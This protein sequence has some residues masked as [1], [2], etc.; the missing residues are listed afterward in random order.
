MK[1]IIEQMFKVQ[2]ELN[3]LANMLIDYPDKRA[4]VRGAY[5]ILDDWI[6]GIQK[7]D[8]NGN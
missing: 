1:E 5:L 3:K 4:E 8:N 2:V 6:E 7:E